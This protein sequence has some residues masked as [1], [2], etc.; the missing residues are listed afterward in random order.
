MQPALQHA[1]TH[2]RD[3]FIQYRR[4]RIFAAARQILGDFQIAPGS[5]IHNDA[6][7]L[8][9]HTQ[10]ANM[11]QRGALRIFDI[12]QQTARR[13]QRQM[14]LL[15]AK[16]AEVA[17]AKLQVELLARGVD[18]KFPQRT[19]TQATALIDQRHSL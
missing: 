2:R 11:R 6:V 8:A 16:A 18:F 19:A 14:R 17:R 5:R 1:A 7:L 9:L 10:R 13:A 4:E 12:L 3:G 15:D